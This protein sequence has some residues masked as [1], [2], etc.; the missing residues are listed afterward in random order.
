MNFSTSRL[1]PSAEPLST[2]VSSPK[3][4]LIQLTWNH[5]AERYLSRIRTNR[6]LAGRVRSIRLL[7]VH[8]AIHSVIDPGNG[9]L[10][11][12]ISEGSSIEA[13]YAAVAKASHDVLASV[14]TAAEDREDLAD[15]LE[16]SLSLIGKEDEKAAGKSSGT[17]SA[18]TY[19]KSFAPLLSNHRPEKPTPVRTVRRELA[20]V[21]GGSSW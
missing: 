3:L 2:T 5:I 18:G 10:F 14:F 13:A 4:D 8:D 11:K 17:D 9:H 20:A 7:A 21:S 1:I 12:E 16:E 19:I 6:I 15:L